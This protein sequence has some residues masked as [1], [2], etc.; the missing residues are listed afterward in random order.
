MKTGKLDPCLVPR[1]SRTKG[2]RKPFSST[3]S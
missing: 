3:S 2:N 1:K